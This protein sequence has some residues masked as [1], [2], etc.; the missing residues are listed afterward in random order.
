MHKL[1]LGIGVALAGSAYFVAT[2]PITPQMALISSLSVLVF[3]LPSYRGVFSITSTQRAFLLLTILGVYALTIETAAIKTGF[4]YGNFT[5]LDVL[6]NKLFST[7]PWTVAFAYPPLVLFGYTLARKYVSKS[8][9]VLIVS[10]LLITTTDLVLDPAAVKLG[11]WY[12]PGGG[13]FYNVPLVNFAGWLLTSYIAST[14]VH[15]ILKKTSAKKLQP[16]AH[17]GLAIL[18]FWLWVNLWLAQ[19]IPVI[20]GTA[21]CI[22]CIRLIRGK[23]VY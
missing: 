19:F 11:F 23:Q 8:Y 6:G 1:S 21:I 5:Y 2:Q 12:W 15:S 14:I 3:A 9:L 20:V 17:S 7:T 22:I 16:L 13:I 10:T 4:P 18:W